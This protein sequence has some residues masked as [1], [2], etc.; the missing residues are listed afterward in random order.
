ML[1]S[2]IFRIPVTVLQI[3]PQG[4]HVGIGHLLV[5]AGVIGLSHVGIVDHLC[6]PV[7]A[8]FVHPS[9]FLDDRVKPL[10]EIFQGFPVGDGFVNGAPQVDQQVAFH[11]PG[12]HK[13]P[14]VLAFP[15]VI[16][17]LR[18]QVD[19]LGKE[20]HRFLKGLGPVYFNGIRHWS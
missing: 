8:A 10:P 18:R 20:I 19:F 12:H 14:G 16:P 11:G 9:G 3:G 2:R 4:R 7:V 1:G 6:P 17:S 5:A 15:Q 13:A